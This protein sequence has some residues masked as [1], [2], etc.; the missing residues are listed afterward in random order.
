VHG[1]ALE[2]ATEMQAGPSMMLDKKTD[3]SRSG[4]PELSGALADRGLGAC[5]PIYFSS[6]WAFTDL[7][8]HRLE[9]CDSDKATIQSLQKLSG[10]GERCGIAIATSL[11][12]K[13]APGGPAL[14]L[15]Q[16]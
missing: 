7:T 12:G 8:S 15:L 10:F 3:F 2:R 16:I 1:D 6:A 4:E 13:A 9:P 14:E 5:T 11:S